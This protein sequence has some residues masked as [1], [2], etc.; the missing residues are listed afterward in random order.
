MRPPGQGA[1]APARQ[2]RQVVRPILDQ[3]QTLGTPPGLN[4]LLERPGFVDPVEGEAPDQTHRATSLGV[5]R[6]LAVLVLPQPPV[7]VVVLPT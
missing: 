4:L 1:V 3:S 2:A 5:R 7:E 6:T